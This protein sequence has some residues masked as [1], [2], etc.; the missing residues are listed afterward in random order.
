MRLVDPSFEG[1][2]VPVDPPLVD[3]AIMDLPEDTIVP[4]ELLSSND[5]MVDTSE[6]TKM[7]GRG[8]ADYVENNAVFGDLGGTIYRCQAKWI[9]RFRMV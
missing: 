3:G 2:I 7:R 8:L 4:L 5:Q 9:Q 6:H 1:A